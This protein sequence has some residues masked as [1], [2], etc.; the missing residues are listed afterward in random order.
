MLRLS[1]LLLLTGAMSFVPRGPPSPPSIALARRR[2]AP[3][4][5]SGSAASDDANARV[6][7]PPLPKTADP[8]VILGIDRSAAGEMDP[9]ALKSAY[10]RQAKAYHPDS[11][12]SESTPEATKKRVNNDFQA[13]NAAYET[14]RVRLGLSEESAT[15]SG[16]R[17]SAARPG[18]R[19][20]GAGRTAK[21]GT[22][23]PATGEKMPGFVGF[24][25]EPG[26]TGSAK[27]GQG[28]SWQGRAGQAPEK[29][30]D[31]SGFVGFTPPA[32]RSYTPN[33]PTNETV[34]QDANASAPSASSA[35]ST[36]SQTP[37]PT[38]GGVAQDA[39][40][41]PPASPAPTDTGDSA[42][43]DWEM[44]AIKER[45]ASLE[46][47]LTSLE[48]RLV[49]ADISAEATE[50]EKEALEERLKRGAQEAQSERERLNVVLETMA[51]SHSQ[52]KEQLEATIAMLKGQVNEVKRPW[53][54]QKPRQ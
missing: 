35:H 48:A 34:A 47:R 26:W 30:V 31:H 49:Q 4:A 25:D 13:I 2:R 38:V 54:Q 11:A 41:T 36:P 32:P 15:K 39:A 12:V 10:H 44:T 23:N 14:L 42:A 43:R 45:Y 8:F 16:R 28:T 24:Q 40:A 53:Y 27:G 33:S 6:P 19:R 22:W 3:K 18:Q 29:G 52:E 7:P 50:R 20:P 51:L 21:E 5:M 9:A 1:F 17:P 46:E 37:P